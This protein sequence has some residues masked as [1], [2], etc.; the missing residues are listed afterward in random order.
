MLGMRRREFIT[1]LRG[2]PVG[3]PLAARAEWTT[4][5]TTLHR[6][7]RGWRM[8]MRCL[9]GY[10]DAPFVAR[11]VYPREYSS[12][13]NVRPRTASGASAILRIPAQVCL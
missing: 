7:K 4:A 1:L 11:L 3:W 12:D 9:G 8:S 2:A 13:L 6:D 10:L 5:K